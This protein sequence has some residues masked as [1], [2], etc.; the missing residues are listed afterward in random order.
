MIRRVQEAFYPASIK[1][2]DQETPLFEK[3][4]FRDF[5]RFLGFLR[6]KAVCWSYPKFIA[7]RLGHDSE[8][9]E[10]CDSPRMIAV[11]RSEGIGCGVG[12]ELRPGCCGDVPC[13]P[14]VAVV[15]EAEGCNVTDGFL[16]EVFGEGIARSD[17][18]FAGA[19]GIFDP[20]PEVVATGESQERFGE[21]AVVFL[22]RV[23]MG[24][25]TR[26]AP[27]KRTRPVA[28]WKSISIAGAERAV[29]LDGDSLAKL[30]FVR[31]EGLRTGD[32][33]DGIL[34]APVGGGGDGQAGG[35]AVDR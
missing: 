34:A 8:A 24:A 27:E 33:S 29:V 22:C 23:A 15:A 16:F 12:S 25:R 4:V 14:E 28:H 10:S 26:A 19:P 9:D 18:Q 2:G 35:V 11:S 21:V 6:A 31:V 13:D 7:A 3:D 32:A 17:Q 30:V 5:I 20:G 1:S